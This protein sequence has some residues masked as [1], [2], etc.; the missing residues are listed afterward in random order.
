MSCVFWLAGFEALNGFQPIWRDPRP[1]ATLWSDAAGTSGDG[2][3]GGW[4]GVLLSPGLDAI[5]AGGTFQGPA[6]S[7]NSTWQELSAVLH[8]LTSFLV[9]GQLS[10]RELQVICDN[11]AACAILG[12]ARSKQPELHVVCVAIHLFC[13]RHDIRLSVS[14]VPREENCEADALSKLHDSGDWVFD[15]TAFQALDQC[16]GPFEIDL[17]ASAHNALTPLFF[18]MLA[19]PGTAGVNAFAH[20]WSGRGLCWCFPPYPLIRRALDRLIAECVTACLVVPALKGAPYWPCLLASGQPQVFAP[21]VHACLLFPTQMGQ[22]CIKPGAANRPG[23][24]P[25]SWGV[26]ALLINHTPGPHVAVPVP[27]L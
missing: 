8:N 1:C 23:A 6:C 25:V 3:L 14:W 2:Y 5:R 13:I 18:S 27:P 20:T 26:V 17:F 19:C 9:P 7:Q 22:S 12:A 24:R 4:G 16:W 15:Q 11:Q 10:G 21:F